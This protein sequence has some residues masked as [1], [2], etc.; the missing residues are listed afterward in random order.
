MIKPLPSPSVSPS[1]MNLLLKTLSPFLFVTYSLMSPRLNSAELGARENPPASDQTPWRQFAAMTPGQVRAYEIEVMRK[2]A[3]LALL[4]P[5]INTAPG[6]QYD[7]VNLEFGMTPKIERT[8]GGRLWCAW[9]GGE[10]GPRAFLLAATS[11]DNGAT[12][13]RPRFVI[14]SHSAFLPVP[15]TT[16]GGVLWL[17]PRGRLWLFSSQGMNYFDGREGVWAA[18]CDNP[19]AAHPAWSSPQRIGHGNLLNKPIVL[20]TGEWLMP[21]YLLQYKTDGASATA[22]DGTTVRPYAGPCTAY[23]T[24]PRC[25]GP[26]T[27]ELFPELD[28]LRGVNLLVSV[29]QGQTWTCQSTVRF[30]D[31]DWHEP[32]VVEKK[33]GSLWMLVRV[34]G[35]IMETTST[36]RGKT[37]TT[38]ALPAVI[39]HPQSRFHLRRLASGRILLIKHGEKIDRHRGRSQLSAWLSEDDG[40]SW[41]GGLMLDE[42]DAVSY[43]DVTEA[44]DGT[45]YIAHDRE[46]I[47][48]GEILL[49][50]VTEADILAGQL[51]SPGSALK[52]L[53]SRPLKGK[54]PD[55]KA[56]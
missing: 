11:D 1:A 18:F 21:S 3:D 5:I 7:A 46:R 38:P 52:I 42:R 36:D 6:A 41:K 24:D 40:R 16:I 22:M 12:W 30:P 43:P 35:G 27:W 9:L 50:R 10:D 28:P 23:L 17:D 56:N 47:K 4:P 14:D 55:R 19:D 20:S 13:S 8:R 49:S 45:L 26:H 33:D 15:R 29:D 32:M 34:K 54:A 53:I 25:P 2:V 37:W 48:L 31:P 39:R 51:R 44:A